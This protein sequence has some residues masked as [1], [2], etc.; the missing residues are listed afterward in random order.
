VYGIDLHKGTGKAVFTQEE[1]RLGKLAEHDGK[2]YFSVEGSAGTYSMIPYPHSNVLVSIDK[3]NGNVTRHRLD[4][5]W[6]SEGSDGAGLLRFGY[7]S[8]SG[9]VAENQPQAATLDLRRISEKAKKVP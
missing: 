5:G 6:V 7:R 1:A 8:Y 9:V 4:K 3:A 2:I